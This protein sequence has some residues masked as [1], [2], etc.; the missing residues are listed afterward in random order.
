[1]NQLP[2]LFSM[3]WIIE[4][5]DHIGDD[6]DGGEEQGEQ[7]EQGNSILPDLDVASIQQ[8]EE[9]APEREEKP[10]VS[11]EASDSAPPATAGEGGDTDLPVE[12]VQDSKGEDV[13]KEDDGGGET[14]ANCAKR[15]EP[16]AEAAEAG[17]NSKV[18]SPTPAAGDSETQ[19]T[20][21]GE[22]VILNHTKITAL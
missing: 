16:D 19:A 4:G 14:E 12:K 8:Q 20:D 21:L 7:R 18:D 5:D 10:T 13:K 6:V 15:E 2:F 22:S 17:S 11:A 9:E 1:M 3:P